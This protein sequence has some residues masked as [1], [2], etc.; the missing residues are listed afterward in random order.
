MTGCF[1]VIG[2]YAV[3]QENVRGAFVSGVRSAGNSSCTTS[4]FYFRGSRMH[5]T[6]AVHSP[7]A[8]TLPAHPPSWWALL[9]PGGTRT[10]LQEPDTVGM[11][12][13]A[14]S[15]V[16][17]VVGHRKIHPLQATLPNK[18]MSKS[19]LL[20]SWRKEEP[21]S[22][23]SGRGAWNMPSSTSVGRYVQFS[24]R[25]HSQVSNGDGLKMN[26]WVLSVLSWS[27]LAE[28]GRGGLAVPVHRVH[29]GVFQAEAVPVAGWGP[30][31]EISDNV[32][33]WG[34]SLTMVA[35]SWLANFQCTA[36]LLEVREGLNQMFHFCPLQWDLPE[37]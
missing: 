4:F 20:S 32:L 15:S 26:S 10:G 2:G 36:S 14:W 30:C 3:S 31:Q 1:H 25:A 17:E 9:W 28:G 35:W 34:Q 24:Q 29:A 5:Q 6:S 21:F 7:P 8:A 33:E 37:S 13:A 19:C 12:S 18:S 23:G 16:G 22:M 27:L 11:P